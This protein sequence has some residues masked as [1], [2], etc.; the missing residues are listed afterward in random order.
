MPVHIELRKEGYYNQTQLLFEVTTGCQGT[1]AGVHTYMCAMTM[2]DFLRHQSSANV[3]LLSSLSMLRI[4]CA[5]ISL[6]VIIQPICSSAGQNLLCRCCSPM[7]QSW[8]SMVTHAHHRWEEE[9]FV[10][11]MSWKH[12]LGANYGGGIH[13][14]HLPAMFPSIE[15]VKAPLPVSF[16]QH[17]F[18]AHWHFRIVCMPSYEVWF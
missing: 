9:L 5:D 3:G 6:V 11:T 1:V 7:D 4:V 8:V 16:S 15:H 12:F 10:L 13:I 2:A 14:P 18:C 17:W